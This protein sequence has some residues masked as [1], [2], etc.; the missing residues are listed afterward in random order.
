[1]ALALTSVRL[2][3]LLA[4]GHVVRAEALVELVTAA[5][6]R[7]PAATLAVWGLDLASESRRVPV[8]DAA[9]TLIELP[10]TRDLALPAGAPTHYRVT[11]F[12]GTERVQVWPLF[13][14]PVSDGPEELVN[15]LA[16]EEIEGGALAGTLMVELRAA[17]AAAAGSAQQAAADRAET[18]ADREQTGLDAA[19]TAADREQTGLD[20]AATAADREQTG[21]DAAAT[22]ADR[23]Q[24]ELD[25]AATAA[26][27]EQTG[28]DAAATAADRHT[29]TL[30]G[31]TMRERAVSVA[32][33][34]SVVLPLDGRPTVCVLDA[35]AYLVA[36]M[37]AA[38]C[39]T[40]DLFLYYDG[41]APHTL[42][43]DGWA[44]PDQIAYAVETSAAGYWWLQLSV[45][46]ALDGARVLAA[47][48]QFFGVPS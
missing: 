32:A 35:D 18:T 22:A 39:S 48:A 25:A 6:A 10:A 29:P 47:S 5:G 30:D 3:P 37:P 17:Q 21:L 41:V 27:R 13:Q 28:L 40:T 26:D 33:H 8:V 36:L 45:V 31:Y 7:A 43:L 1:M 2:P 11:Y 14:V 44:T 15:L 42:D 19:A 4:G 9:G 34:G 24:T 38:G 20:A 12:R 23:E 46:P 16:A